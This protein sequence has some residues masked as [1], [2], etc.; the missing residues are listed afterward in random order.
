MK[1]TLANST[2]VRQILMKTWKLKQLKR[3]QSVYVS[4]DRSPVERAARRLLV[5]ERKKKKTEGRP[6]TR[7]GKVSEDKT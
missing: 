5:Q 3:L 2:T 1:V 4:P 6:N 7:G